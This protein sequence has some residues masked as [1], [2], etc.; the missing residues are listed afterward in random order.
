MIDF[1]GFAFFSE[2]YGANELNARC[3]LF[4]EKPNVTVKLVFE[5][6]RYDNSKVS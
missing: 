3:Q 2:A 1:F 6:L 5:Q 4:V